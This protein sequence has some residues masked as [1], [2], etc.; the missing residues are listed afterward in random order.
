MRKPSGEARGMPHVLAK[1]L[2]GGLNAVTWKRA[3]A[4]LSTALLPVGDDNTQVALIRMKAGGRINEHDHD[5]DEFTVIL[6]GGFSDD[7][8]SYHA[9][10]FVTCTRDDRHQ[11]VAH[12]NEECICLA[13][14]AAPIKFTG[15]K[16]L[17]LNPLVAFSPG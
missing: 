16:G 10:D 7:R 13:A 6:K 17:L 9:G 12:Q 3:T 5:G 8:G 1:L 11:P 15:W 4:S 2:P 14:Q